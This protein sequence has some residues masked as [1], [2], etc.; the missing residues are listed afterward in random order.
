MLGFI[1]AES[2]KVFYQLFALQQLEDR[3]KKLLKKGQ[4]GEVERICKGELER[5]RGSVNRLE[6]YFAVLRLVPCLIE[7]AEEKDRKRV[8][9]EWEGWIRVEDWEPW[10]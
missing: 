9:R 6:E 7:A 4:N 5:C 2:T 10:S 3:A 1:S 8:V